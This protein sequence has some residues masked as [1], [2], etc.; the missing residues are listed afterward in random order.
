MIWRGLSALDHMHADRL[1]EEQP[2]MEEG[3]RKGA[4]AIGEQREGVAIF[5]LPPFLVIDPL[6]HLGIG[7]RRRL[8][9]LMRAL[10]SLL[11]EELVREWHRRL[12]LQTFQL[13]PQRFGD[14]SN[15]RSRGGDPLEER[16][17]INVIR[18]DV[19]F[20]TPALLA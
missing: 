4:R 16:S 8:V 11:L 18:H 15:R 19:P 17:T 20:G 7:S 9:G 1:L 6:K 12:E 2:Q 14:R 3:D 10:A 5:D 13:C